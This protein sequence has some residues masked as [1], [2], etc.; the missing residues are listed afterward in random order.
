ML[1]EDV[2]GPEDGKDEWDAAA[3]RLLA[4]ENRL[5]AHEQ[6]LL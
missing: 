4:V 5:L 6:L 3:D 2:R 1:R